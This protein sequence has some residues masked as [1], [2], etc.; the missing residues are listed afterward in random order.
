MTIR[1]HRVLIGFVL[2]SA[3]G[4]AWAFAAC[5]DS[6]RGDLPGAG[7]AGG[8]GAGGHGQGG[9]AGG[10]LQDGA[11]CETT[12]SNDL[13]AVVNC[14]GTVVT[15][16]TPDQGCANAECIDNPCQAAELSKSSYGCDY[17]ALKTAQ[18]PQ[19]DG[20][21]FAAFV[22]NT[23]EKEVHLTVERNGQTLPVA[24]FARIPVVQGANITYQP[25]DDAAGLAVGEMAIL[26][27]SRRNIG[28]AAVKACP[29]TP[30]LSVE[31]GVVDTG[32]GNA[33]H[34][35]TDYPVV[36]YQMVP[37]GGAESY[38]AGATLL[39]PTSAWDTNYIAI[40][41]YS[42]SD[43]PV[44]GGVPSLNIVASQD[45]TDVTLLPG[46]AIA[47]GPGVPGASANTQVTYTLNAGQFL[48]ITQPAELTGS[49][50]LS[51]K[52]VGVF[53]A[54]TCMTVPNNVNDCDSAQQQIAPVRALGNEYAAVRYRA[55]AGN[56]AAVWRAV[57]AVN[58]TEL[59]WTP[60]QPAGAPSTIGRGEV[61]EFQGPGPFT[62]RSQDANHPF[63]LAEYMTGGDPFGGAGDPEWVNV[64]PPSQYLN[65][66]VLFTDATYPETSLVVTRTRSKV[67][68]SFADVTLDCAGVLT[69]WQAIGDYE[70]TRVDLVTGNFQSVN[71]CENG[72]HE[73][74]SALPFGV[75]V[76][77]WGTTADTQFVSYG[78]PA[79]AGFQ[80][81]NDIVVP[82]TPE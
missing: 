4:T 68:G 25:Y 49:P 52:P 66:Y 2:T 7:G 13:K 73:M 58:G 74:S 80:P 81:I 28:G 50:I 65:Y 3:L 70:Y 43:P 20:A 31:T 67:D 17:W 34:I 53:G 15:Q 45:A 5:T 10:L 40:N 78:Y 57:G 54:H 46:V 9:H 79:G 24:N 6:Y 55:R 22:A 33:F 11:I 59:T 56:E 8:S 18:R 76:W 16:C 36:A 29:V 32:I 75:T 21:C 23:W 26:F 14:N 1:N 61:V 44:P 35:R 77:G 48:Q 42:S 69:G 37:Y 51:T 64:I 62:V 27:L 82:P 47:G 60:S 12:C 41:G 39:L 63:Y 19:A 72:R 30:A 38:V 71:G